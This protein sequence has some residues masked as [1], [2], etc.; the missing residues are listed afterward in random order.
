MLTECWNEFCKLEGQHPDETNDFKDGIHKCQYVLGMRFA[1]KYR[2]DLFY[3]KPKKLVPKYKLGDEFIMHDT[4]L[5]AKIIAID[6]MECPIKYYLIS[7]NNNYKI[8]E[9]EL[10]LDRAKKLN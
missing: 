2:P 1:R 8:M 3:T 5:Y 4:G 7:Y 10:D 9:Y 6:L